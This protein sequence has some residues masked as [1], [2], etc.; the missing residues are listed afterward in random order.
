MRLIA[1]PWQPMTSKGTPSFKHYTKT[2]LSMTQWPMWLRY[3]YEVWQTGHVK[4]RCKLHLHQVVTQY[5][6]MLSEKQ[7]HWY[8]LK[9]TEMLSKCSIWITAR[10]WFRVQ[11]GGAKQK[12]ILWFSMESSEASHWCSMEGLQRKPWV[13]PGQRRWVPSHVDVATK[14]TKNEKEWKRCTNRYNIQRV[15]RWWRGM[16][17]S[18]SGELS[19]GSLQREW[20]SA[21]DW[22]HGVA[23]S[24]L[25]ARVLQSS[26][27]LNNRAK[28]MLKWCRSLQNI[29]KRHADACRSQLDCIQARE[30]QHDGDW[31]SIRAFGLCFLG[32]PGKPFQVISI[33]VSHTAKNTQW[34]QLHRHLKPVQPLELLPP[35]PPLRP[36]PGIHTSS[37]SMSRY[38][39]NLN[40]W[41][42][43]QKVGLVQ[44]VLPT[45]P[46]LSSH[47]SLGF[48]LLFWSR[49]LI[50]VLILIIVI[51]GSLGLRLGLCFRGLGS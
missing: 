9:K 34:Q 35:L 51:N 40:Q 10:E 1:L 28:N 27:H 45:Y 26:L 21:W 20:R 11:T 2:V 22:L 32:L 47:P 37:K 42:E 41:G 6:A 17:Q 36:R 48:C 15:I 25:L 38:D 31:L 49:L 19:L 43:K 12:V 16:I 18:G 46:T 50:V 5:Y 39:G 24:L 29:Q 7:G 14:V 3:I 8:F 33:H 13:H 44:R 23:K 4:T 30:K